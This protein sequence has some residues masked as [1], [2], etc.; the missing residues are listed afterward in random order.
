MLY[1]H[2]VIFCVYQKFNQKKDGQTYWDSSTNTNYA[3]IT[4]YKLREAKV[5]NHIGSLWEDSWGLLWGIKSYRA[6]RTQSIK[7]CNV[8]QRLSR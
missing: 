6:E 7:L 2:L 4:E 3:I 1:E 5:L 8:G